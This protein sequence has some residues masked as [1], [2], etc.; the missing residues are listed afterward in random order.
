M[1]AKEYLTKT[2][3]P[4]QMWATDALYFRVVGWLEDKGTY[5]YPG[6]SYRTRRITY[7]FP[8]P[9]DNH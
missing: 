5:P 4:H 9:P 6:E 2:T 8:I 1:A 3:Q 7:T